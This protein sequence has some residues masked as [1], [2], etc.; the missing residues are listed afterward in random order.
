MKF[1]WALR[2][3]IGIE[4]FATGRPLGFFPKV[5]FWFNF[6]NVLLSF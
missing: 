5:S 2:N 4:S 1:I 6:G 3:C